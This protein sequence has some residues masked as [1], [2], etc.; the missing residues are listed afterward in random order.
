MIIIYEQSLKIND[1]KQQPGIIN[2]T[3]VSVDTKR[4]FVSFQPVY[5]DWKTSFEPDHVAA[6]TLD[7]EIIEE[8]YSPRQSFF[9]HKR[10]TP[11][12]R[13]QAFYFA[14]YAVHP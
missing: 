3:Y 6:L 13:L 14:S 1:R 4:Q 8:L 7:N 11:W 5:A 2:D 10:E 12:T 9:N